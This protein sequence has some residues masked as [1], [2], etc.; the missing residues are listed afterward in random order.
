VRVPRSELT[1][2]AGTYRQPATEEVIQ[3]L[4]TGDTLFLQ[5]DTER[6]ALRPLG[7]GR[8]RVGNSS[9]EISFT[10]AAPD[11]AMRLVEHV[12]GRSPSTYEPFRP[13]TLATAQLAEYGGSYYAE[14]LDVRWTILPDSGKL[15]VRIPG[16]DTL[17][18]AP[19]VR[20]T[21][22]G[23][24]ITLRFTRRGNRVAGGILQAGRVRNIRFERLQART[25]GNEE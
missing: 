20:D 5:E 8:F 17:R 19:T 18:L 15:V 2:Y 1:R 13:V 9:R 12:T 10:A 6:A 22:V 3:I 4:L 21:F 24:G 16:G 23:G 14:E 11:G 7:S 25:M